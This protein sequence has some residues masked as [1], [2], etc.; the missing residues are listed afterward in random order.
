MCGLF[1]QMMEGITDK[2]PGAQ[3]ARGIQAYQ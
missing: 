2:N 3:G 1:P